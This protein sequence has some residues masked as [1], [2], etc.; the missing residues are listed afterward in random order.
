MNKLLGDHQWL[1]AVGARA[2]LIGA[3]RGNW[4]LILIA[5]L[6]GSCLGAMLLLDYEIFF[7]VFQ[8]ITDGQDFWSPG[9]MA[10]TPL[11][12]LIAFHALARHSPKH[13]VVRLV[14]KMASIFILAFLLGGGLYIA[15]LL[16]LDA[17]AP[18]AAPLPLPP[19]GGV[20]PVDDGNSATWLDALFANITSPAGVLALSLGIGG[21]SVVSVFA[22]HRLILTIETTMREV[23]FAQRLLREGR[24]H[25]R[26][27]KEAEAK[28]A[29]LAAEY[30]RLMLRTDEQLL[31]HVAGLVLQTINT[32]CMPHEKRLQQLRFARPDPLLNF[33]PAEEIQQIE[34]ALKPIRDI[35]LKDVLNALSPT[36]IARSSK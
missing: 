1:M 16:Y 24:A 14:E 18:T 28:F 9:L 23:Y 34:A 8:F 21:L 32:H 22:G 4:F 27:C 10:L 35:T 36:A 15:A 13:L 29:E 5:T 2:K 12:M 19:M 7:R 17:G 25:Y 20:P 3:A 33:D 30:D 6:A 31:V 26:E 11:T